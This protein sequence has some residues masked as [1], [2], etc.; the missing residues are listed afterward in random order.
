MSVVITC[1][2]L[3]AYID[4]AIDSVL[5]QEPGVAGPCEIIVVDDCST[6]GSAAR[7]RARQGVT[8]LRTQKNAGVLL[9]TL[10]GIR[11][12]R[13]DIVCFLDGDDEWEP[14]KLRRVADCFAADPGIA[15]VTH[16]L[17]TID[18]E[19]R[20]VGGRTR[21]EEVMGAI[22]PADWP[23]AVLRGIQMHLDYVWLGSAY[24]LRRRTCD[25]PGFEALVA[26]LP[27][28]ANTYQDWPLAF[29]V[30]CLPGAGFG[31]V[32]E[33]LFRYRLHGANHSGD[34]TSLAKAQRNFQ[35]TANTLLAIVRVARQAQPGD[36]VTWAMER[37]LAYA[38]CLVDLYAGS[39][40]AACRGFA[41]SIPHLLSLR[42]EAL[43]ECLRFAG[44]LLLGP[45]RFI[46]LAARAH[47]A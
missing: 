46:A 23:A 38:R 19:G 42:G 3:E 21:V 47:A 44:I 15:L 9:A 25:L 26:G 24:C 22:A 6:D 14:A 43:K 28:P 5:G 37:R 20:P 27:D 35:R 13:G 11:A 7:I 10:T 2:N 36:A 18:A 41:T 4:R 33:K 32:P 45:E 30:A 8:Y 1:Y 29:W 40:W 17:R 39:R 34:A 12:S 31:Y 16:D